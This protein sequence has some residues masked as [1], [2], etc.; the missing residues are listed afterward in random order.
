MLQSTLPRHPATA[1][2]TMPQSGTTDRMPWPSLLSAHNVGERQWSNFGPM[3]Q[4]G[5]STNLSLPVLSTPIFKMQPTLEGVVSGE[6]FPEY[7]APPPIRAPDCNCLLLLTV[8]AYQARA[9]IVRTPISSSIRRRRRY[10]F[11]Y[12]LCSSETCAKSDSL[13][14]LCTQKERASNSTTTMTKTKRI[15]T[16]T[17]TMTTKTTKMTTTAK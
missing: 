1:I 14:V 12:L 2:K 3:L 5:T 8:R 16:T 13:L 15:L 10:I 9:G 6:H 11:G 4:P 17:T 7:K